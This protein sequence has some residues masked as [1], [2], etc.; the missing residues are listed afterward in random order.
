MFA[1]WGANNKPKEKPLQLFSCFGL[2]WRLAWW[3]QRH[4]GGQ[5]DCPRFHSLENRQ[6]CKRYTDFIGV[7]LLSFFNVAA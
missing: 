6:V 5:A 3:S 2:Q 7:G 1:V 4:E